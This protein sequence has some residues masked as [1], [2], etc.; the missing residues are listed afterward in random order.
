MKKDRTYCEKYCKG[1]QEIHKCFVDGVC[2]AY[3]KQVKN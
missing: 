3:Q 2:S 1:W